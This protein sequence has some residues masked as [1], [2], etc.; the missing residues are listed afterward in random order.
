MCGNTKAVVEATIEGRTMPLCW[1][2]VEKVF[3]AHAGIVKPKNSKKPTEGEPS[4]A[5]SG[6]KT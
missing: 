4:K 2:D 5:D 1:K 6:K 3:N